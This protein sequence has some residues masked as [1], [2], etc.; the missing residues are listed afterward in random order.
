MATASAERA[1]RGPG[2]RL[3]LSL[4]ARLAIALFALLATLA[5]VLL[6]YVVPRTAAAFEQH[7]EDLVREGTATMRE[8]SAAQTAGSSTVL[9]DLIRHT[10]AARART[11]E[12]LPLEQAGAV[13]SI[14]AEIAAEDARR[15]ERQQRNVR[16]LAREMQRRA[17]EQIAGHLDALGREQRLRTAAF[18]RELRTVH[19]TLVGL[20]LVVLLS[21][22]ALGLHLFVVR[23]TLRLRRATQRVA[24]GDLAVELPPA[25]DDELGDLADDFAGMVA[26]LRSSRRELERLAAGLELEVQK[27]T[28]HLELALKEL[29]SSHE[30][31]AQA[32]RLA[33]LGTLAG[34]IAHEFHNL[35]GGIRGCAA[36]LLVDEAVPE[37]R[38]TLGV[39]M[40]AADRAT[41][42]VQQLL[43]FARRSIDQEAD[44]DP[45]T[46]VEDA[47]RLCEP[48]ARRQQVRVERALQ[49]GLHVRG[50]ADALHQVVVNLLTNALQAMP[51]G[52]TLRV[53]VAARN[54]EVAVEVADSGAGIAEQDL[55]HVFEPFFTRR[56]REGD[57]ARRGTGLGLSVSYGIVTAHRG[58]IVA[59]SRPGHGA[60]FTVTLPRAEP[61]G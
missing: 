16:V 23:P 51:S 3:R 46:V 61:Q 4:S 25:A 21:V 35:I 9:V 33:A 47:L 6:G 49:P 1:G 28:Q 5:A 40:R 57:P 19:A 17:D 50:D 27:K 39:V 11:L 8:L 56:D 34:G 45:A 52:G 20:A 44:V 26:Q 10:A 7:G 24:A 31:L 54:G 14:R 60:S 36:E 18:A 29:R 12:D 15:S 37:R 53:Q 48:A 38:E 58:R 32:E 42:V 43:R 59:A 30:H 22:L 55:P 41:G 2:K 13:A